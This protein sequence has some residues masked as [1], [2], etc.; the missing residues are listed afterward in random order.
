MTLVVAGFVIKL[1]CT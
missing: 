1:L